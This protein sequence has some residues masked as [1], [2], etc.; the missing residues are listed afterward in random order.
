MLALGAIALQRY[1]LFDLFVERPFLGGTFAPERRA[2]DRPIAMACL[3]LVTLFPDFPLLSVPRLRSCIALLTFAAA[4]LPYLAMLSLR[5]M[6]GEVNYG[7]E[8][9]EE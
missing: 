8:V 1:L 5:V 3:A 6:S 9:S 4:R 2:S 7:G